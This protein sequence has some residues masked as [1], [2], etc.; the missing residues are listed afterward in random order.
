MAAS[1]GFGMDAS[2]I[3]MKYPA[4]LIVSVSGAVKTINL[5]PSAVPLTSTAPLLS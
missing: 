2:A 5:P 3:W 4:W 1:M